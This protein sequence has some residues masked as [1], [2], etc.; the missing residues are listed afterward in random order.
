ML[1]TDCKFCAFV[2]FIIAVF[3]AFLVAVSVYFVPETTRFFAFFG[4]EVS[5][6]FFNAAFVA[7]AGIGVL[8]FLRFIS[9]LIAICFD[10]EKI[11]E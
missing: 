5:A 3:C 8:S 4:L 9:S 6:E 2:M 7:G 1:K 10:D 11:D